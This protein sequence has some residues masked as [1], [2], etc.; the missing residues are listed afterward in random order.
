MAA[1]KAA[2]EAKFRNV[3]K[4]GP[5]GVSYFQFSTNTL[6]DANHLVAKLFKKTLVADVEIIE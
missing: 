5:T 1:R 2:Y 4:V 6:D 3:W